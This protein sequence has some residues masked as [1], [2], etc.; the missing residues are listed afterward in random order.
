MSPITITLRE[1]VEYKNYL[2][3]DFMHRRHKKRIRMRIS[4][5]QDTWKIMEFLFFSFFNKTSSIQVMKDVIDMKGKIK[6]FNKR[7]GYGFI[8]G[9]DGKD[10]FVHQS[11]IASGFLSDG[12]E[13]EYELE[14][15]ERGMSAKNVQRV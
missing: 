11:A 8:V 1:V 3:N 15:T 13:V 5:F 14:E 9:E 12:D 4:Y 2:R 6:W 10:I 7:K